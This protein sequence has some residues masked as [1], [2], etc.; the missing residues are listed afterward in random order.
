MKANGI[1][2]S[3]SI[4]HGHYLSM[5]NR[6]INLKNSSLKVS[7][8]YFSLGVTTTSP[9]RAGFKCSVYQNW[10]IQTWHPTNEAMPPSRTCSNNAASYEL[11]RNKYVRYTL[12]RV[13]SAVS[14]VCD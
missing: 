12:S 4:T 8:A 10:F 1:D 9:P 13:G 14:E 7:N 6:F 3:W 5:W 11:M 2:A